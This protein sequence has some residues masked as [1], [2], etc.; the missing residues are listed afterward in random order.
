MNSEISQRDLLSERQLSELKERKDFINILSIASNWLQM[1]LAMIIFYFFPS[2]V[3]FL[4]GVIIVGSR[5]FALAV[6]MHEASHNLLF[7]DKKVNDF[8]SQWFCAYPIFSDTKPYRP[9]HLAHHRFTET[10]RDPDL[11][12]S[13]PFP[14][15]RTS[16]M[17]KIFRDLTGLTGLRR[18]SIA[19]SS[20]FRTEADTKKEKF[21]LIIKKAHRVDCDLSVAQKM[22]L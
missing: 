16:F 21:T 17:R 5:Q 14:I 19:F 1:A 2:L 9:Y 18:Y 15:T 11:V 22:D 6:L 20:I 13:A 8:I 7:K 10:T 12:L 4:I 3:T